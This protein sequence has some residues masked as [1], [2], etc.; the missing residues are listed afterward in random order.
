[1]EATQDSSQL[2]LVQHLRSPEFQRDGRWE[3]R[4]FEL[5]LNG[6][7]SIRD[8][9]PKAGP[10]QMPYLFCTADAEAQEPV[11][12]VLSWLSERGI[13]LALNPGKEVPDY[14]FTYGMVWNLRE[15]GTFLSSADSLRLDGVSTPTPASEVTGEGAR[16]EQTAKAGEAPTT[17]FFTMESKTGFIAGPPTEAFLP[18]YVRKILQQ[19]FLEQAL[20]DVKTLVISPDGKSFDLCFSL[21]S[22]GNPPGSEHAGI[23]E[24]LSWFVP[25]HYSLAIVSEKGLPPFVSMDPAR[26]LSNTPPPQM[27]ADLCP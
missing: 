11:R 13:G 1:M 15:R 24:A 21:E 14:V 18:V 12:K 17:Q 16:F 22:M 3:A 2:A 4:F 10:D 26:L 7:V 23:L 9:A 20:W 25:A 6:H 27:G 19:F 8:G 5:F